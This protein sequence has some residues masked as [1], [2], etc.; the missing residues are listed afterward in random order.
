MVVRIIWIIDH[1]V[2]FWVVARVACI[3]RGVPHE[4]V[5]Q[6]IL[7]PVDSRHLGLLLEVEEDGSAEVC[8]E[9][10]DAGL[11]PVLGEKLSSTAIKSITRRGVQI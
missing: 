6:P 1:E 8:G 2:R 4:H 10:A 11:V 5:V 9:V 3:G 7:V